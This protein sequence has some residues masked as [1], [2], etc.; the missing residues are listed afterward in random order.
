V[1]TDEA[2]RLLLR[3]GMKASRLRRTGFPVHPKFT[4]YEGPPQPARQQ[5]GLQ[6]DRF[7]VLVTSGGVGSGNMGE[8]VHTLRH[9]FP[10]KQVLV[11]TGKNR[12]LY[13]QLQDQQLGPH[14]HLY[15]FVD[16]MET[17]MAA[18]D[19]VVSKAGPGTLMEA[20]AMRRPAIVTEAVG[21]QERG[22]ID[23]VL[24][25]E[26]GAFC[27]TTERI[28]AA[29][30]DLSDPQRYAAT[31]QRLQDAVPRDGALQ[32][33]D[34]MLKQLDLAAPT[35]RKP[36]RRMLVLR[37]PGWRLALYRT[38]KR[39]KPTPETLRPVASGES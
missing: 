1:P 26:L 24:N 17:L 29:V 18:S 7:T 10:E 3:R 35:A 9:H 6:P 5:L 25:Y 20:L 38:R 33:A 19:V 32:I 15:G 37:F 39:R 12:G 4:R 22:N 16:N 28:V 21:M 13:D 31:V 8:L 23:F 27:P 36:R 30:D 2:Y 11:V 14:V 34:H